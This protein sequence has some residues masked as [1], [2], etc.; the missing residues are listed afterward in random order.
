MKMR[1]VLIAVALFLAGCG[2]GQAEIVVAVGTTLDDSGFMGALVRAYETEFPDRE[3]VV[4]GRSSPE[5]LALGGA[6]SADLLITHAPREEAAFV[7]DGLALRSEQVFGSQFVLVAPSDVAIELQGME[8][9][10]VLQ[11]LFSHPSL[12]FHLSGR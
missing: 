4:V 6:G 9:G 5:V 1:S 10:Q 7:A 3:V 2:G 12:R 8:I 11:G